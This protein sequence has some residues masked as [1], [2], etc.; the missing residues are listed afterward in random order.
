MKVPVFI[1]ISFIYPTNIP[2][3]LY[4][5]PTDEI[6]LKKSTMVVNINNLPTSSNSQVPNNYRGAVVRDIFINWSLTQLFIVILLV[7]I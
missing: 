5:E 2:W 7:I 1:I 3:A 6:K 4:Y